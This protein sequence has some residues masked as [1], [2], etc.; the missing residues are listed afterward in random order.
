MQKQNACSIKLLRSEIFLSLESSQSVMLL[1][2]ESHAIG[3]TNLHW[4]FVRPL[5]SACMTWMDNLPKSIQII[6]LIKFIKCAIIWT[7]C[8][9]LCMQQSIFSDR[10]RPAEL[11]ML[12]CLKAKFAEDIHDDSLTKE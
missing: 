2:V 10:L 6:H 1:L 7:I 9:Q 11:C 3:F 12:R 5:T 4:Q 8:V